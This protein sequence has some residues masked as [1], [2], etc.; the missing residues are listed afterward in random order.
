[1]AEADKV[2]I[3]HRILGVEDGVAGQSKWALVIEVVAADMAFVDKTV[4]A[5]EELRTV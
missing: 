4:L 2:Q 1:M 5:A 3:H